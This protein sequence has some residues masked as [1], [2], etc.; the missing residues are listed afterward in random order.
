MHVRYSFAAVAA[1][2]VLLTAPPANAADPAELARIN[3]IVIACERLEHDYAIYRDQGDA[4]AF[5]NI[6]TEDAEWG[7]S[8]GTVLTGRE[9]IRRH[10][11]T[12]SK[13]DRGMHNV[14]MQSQ[15]TIQITPIDDTTATGVSYGLVLEAPI[16]E[17][18]L[19]ATNQF[20]F[21]VAS[22]SLS[23][24]KLTDDGWK[25]AKREYTQLFVDPE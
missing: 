25:I 19:P 18:G 23:T 1:V 4:E 3:A 9:A 12:I 15:T 24:Y 13:T 14:H 17:H 2:S 7:R 8:G 10:V 6:F 22:E 20:S 16:P 5:A 21:Q 11:E